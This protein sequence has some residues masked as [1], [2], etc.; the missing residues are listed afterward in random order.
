MQGGKH[1]KELEPGGVMRCERDVIMLLD[2]VVIGGT[3]LGFRTGMLTTLEAHHTM[4]L[5]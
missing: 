1:H 4:S 3:R 2:K 5:G